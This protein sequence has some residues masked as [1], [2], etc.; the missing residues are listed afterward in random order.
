VKIT[1]I[2]P[3][4]GK[5]PGELYIGTWKMEPLTIAALK[6]LTPAEV[7]T[8][9][10]DDRLEC[11]D[12]ET[13]TDAVALSVETYTAQRAYR[14]A[15]EFRQRGVKVILGGYHPTLCPEEALANADAIISGNAESVWREVITD[16]QAGRLQP[17]YTGAPT[18]PPVRPDRSILGRRKYL[19][20]SLV[21]T[22]RGCTFNCEFCA[23][24]AF[25]GSCYRPRRI[26]AII[27]DIENSP[28]RNFFLVDDNIAANPAFTRQLCREIAPLKI[29]WASQ[30]SLTL[31][32]DPALLDA[33]RESGCLLLLIGFESLDAGNLAQ[34]GKG[35]NAR[36]LERREMIR[37]IHAAGIGIYATFVFG[38]D[39]DT[40]AS[41][42]RAVDFSLANG[43]FFAA[44]NHLLPFPG[45]PLYRRL[46]GEN[47]LLR[48]H[49]WLD[50]DYRY[51]DVAFLPRHM[52]PEELSERCAQARREF[53]KLSSIGQRGLKLLGRTISPLAH[54]LF[55][56]QNVNLWREVEEKLKIPI[57][58]G[59]DEFPK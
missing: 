59:L 47:R 25:Y 21:E 31:A 4:I 12:Y 6:A 53:F 5:K 34:M 50:P 45:T 49:W 27:S 3:G 46:Q 7:E 36:L 35:W 8:D 18:A 20:L 39:S 58:S 29:H 41:F 40:P 32:E 42:D 9:F 48:E 15:A 52:S 19:P 57:G 30:G 55:W 26:D 37:R 44:F 38:Y 24:A 10:F 16:L 14:I 56:T 17:V 13:A 33:M 11:I 2:L 1:F 43:F 23:I 51:G 54:F 28:H 22:G